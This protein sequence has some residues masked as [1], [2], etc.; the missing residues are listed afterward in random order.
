[1]RREEIGRRDDADSHTILSDR[2]LDAAAAAADEDG[3]DRF[4]SMT[5]DASSLL[6]Q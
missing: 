2:R 1:V 3:F 6:L 4:S 5:A